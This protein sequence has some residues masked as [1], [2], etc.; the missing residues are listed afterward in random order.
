MRN[1][2]IGG[3]QWTDADF[4]ACSPMARLLAIA[5][6]NYADD[7]GAFRWNPIDLKIRLL[8]IDNVDAAELLQELID[9]NQITRYEVGGKQYGAIRNFHKFQSPKYP[10]YQHP[11]PT[12]SLGDGYIFRQSKKLNKDNSGESREIAELNS[13]NSLPVVSSSSSNLEFVDRSTTT[14]CARVAFLPP[15]EL[16]AHEQRQYAKIISKLQR[17]LSNAGPETLHAMAMDDL[18]KWKSQNARSRGPSQ[19]TGIGGDVA[20]LVGNMKV[21][22]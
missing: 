7:N 14:A 11:I 3:T 4:L 16:P 21:H 12:E 2:S 1:R 15:Q 17:K 6:R 5:L 20:R 22:K 18:T 9:N 8:P 13:T 19:P 10:T